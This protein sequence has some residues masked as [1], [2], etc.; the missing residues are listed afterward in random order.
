[1]HI[2]VANNP[3]RR[4]SI[5]S[6]SF[7]LVFRAVGN[8]NTNHQSFKAAA[9][10][11]ELIPKADLKGQGYKKLSSYEIYGFVGLL[12]IGDLI[13]IGTITRKSRVAQPVPHETVNK[14][15]GVE[16][17]CLNDS[18][19]D[20]LEIN[21]SGYP[22]MPE[23]ESAPHQESVPKHP[24]HEIRKLL[25]NGSFYYSTDFDL[26]STL[27]RRGFISHSLSSD[28]F[29]K[30]YMW[31]SFLMKE[32]IT[33]RDRL[34]VNARQILD[35]EGFLTT[36]I[37]GFAETFITYVKNLKIG[38][39]V[40]SKQ[41]WKR[42]G[43]RFNARGIDDESN[44]ANFVETELIM[45][46]NQYCYSFTQIRGS[47]PIFWEQ[48]TALINPKVSIT[49]SVEATQPVFDEHFVRLTNKYGSVNVINLLSTRSSEIGLTKRYRQHLQLSKKVSLNSDTFLTEFDFHKETSQV[50]FVGSK[51]LLP[52]VTDFI[53]ENGYF[54]YDVREKRVISE[55]HGV[56]RTNCLD[57]LDRTNLVQQMLSLTV[58]KLFLEDF[59]L[60]NSKDYVEDTDFASKHNALWADHG[61]Q[62]SQIYTGTNALKSSFS[63]K[64][65]MSFAGALSDATKSVSRMYINN[66]MDKDKQQNIDALLGRLPHQQAVELYDPI[67]EYVTQQL[68]KKKDNFTSYSSADIFIGTYNVN[69]ISRPTDLS[70]WLFPIGD[71]FKPD[72][73]IL[74]MQEVIEMSAGS[75]LN[76]DSTKGSFWESM[77]SQCLNQFDEKYLL[78]RVQQMTSLL[79]LF[80][81]KKSKAH[82]IKQVEGSSKK[83]G[84]GGMTGNKGA[85]AI[86][87]QY[88]ETSFCAVN[89]HFAAGSG[90]VD[91]RRND[92]ESI[93]KSITFARSKTVRNHDSIFWLGDLNYRISLS[94]EQVR[95]A[96][97][98]KGENYIEKLL[99]YDQL[100]QEINTGV[101]FQ[102]FK[103]PTIQFRPTYKFDIGT[104]RYDSS[105]KA[106]TPSWTD[107]I[108]YRGA[109]LQPLA[110]SDV[111][112]R[113]SDHHPVY[114]AYK[115]KIVCIDENVKNKLSKDLYEEF[116]ASHPNEVGSKVLQLVD[117]DTEANK[118]LEKYKI[119]SKPSSNS[120]LDFD[121]QASP[122]RKSPSNIL[123]SSASLSSIPLQPSSRVSSASEVY[124][125]RNV[126]QPSSRASSTSEE[127]I[128]RNL[129]P[130]LK[131]TTLQSAVKNDGA[132]RFVPEPPKSQSQ[133]PAAPVAATPLQ[134][135]TTERKPAFSSPSP[136]KPRK[137]L[138]PGFSDVILTPKNSSSPSSPALPIAE[139]VKPAA[140]PSLHA[141]T[142]NESTKP[143]T[144]RETKDNDTITKNPP[145][146]PVK[147]AELEHLSMDAWRPLTPK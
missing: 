7:A 59:Q 66:F 40:I 47:V 31:N 19:W 62:I 81:V 67:N 32:I 100:T 17:F 102:N 143:D 68:E 135:S 75:I 25:S 39:T 52:L 74:G 9:C 61:D 45:F 22:I 77:V 140:P 82:K 42:A 1:M 91:E 76:A 120:L 123:S 83:T 6:N 2:L 57:C 54:S 15:S 10:A 126:Q 117:I 35:D 90:N 41:S 37:R 13:F 71:K 58:F 51:K 103:E 4:I 112:M 114:A 121:I 109:N 73:V 134:G 130:P 55:Q 93:M 26:T 48:D 16:F 110:Y 118:I 116:K 60:I 146:V 27:Q 99:T 38:L 69:G 21:S 107:R 3:D 128:T 53:L 56:F 97:M 29:E 20:Y 43:T 85:V 115:A 5:V 87:F 147:K 33:Y 11:V 136:P 145:T 131:A 44:V 49:R 104:N 79:M 129:P 124:L 133:P 125:P 95:K 98:D 36:V 132:T 101:V 70:Q 113:I 23:S 28:N 72:I 106:R 30:E 24:C 122:S 144:K 108:V 89:A 86:R 139:K 12:E 141:K 94:N 88:N 80:F 105:E 119:S 46:S 50:G 142:S 111:D 63:R 96:L 34:D 18:R 92:Y 127:S 8:K 14:I 64:G 78:L 84:F 137:A 65:K 138:P